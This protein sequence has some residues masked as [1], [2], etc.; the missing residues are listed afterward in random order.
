MSRKGMSLPEHTGFSSSSRREAESM[1]RWGCRA[2]CWNPWRMRQ[3]KRSGPPARC[4]SW[5]KR[6]MPS[7]TS[8]RSSVTMLMTR[9]RPWW[10][11]RVHCLWKPLKPHGRRSRR[12]VSRDPLLPSSLLPWTC[13]CQNFYFTGRSFILPVRHR[14]Q[15]YLVEHL[16]E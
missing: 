12:S 16:F 3:W 14:R 10:R 5:R 6:W 8:F 4:P 2:P 1:W 15:S 13:V 9:S 7:S 11:R